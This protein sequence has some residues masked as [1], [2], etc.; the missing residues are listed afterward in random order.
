[1]KNKKNIYKSYIFTFLIV[2]CLGLLC[3]NYVFARA[4]VDGK[5]M[6]NTLHNKDILFVEKISL[7]TN[8]ISKGNIII[9]DSHNKRKEIF[10][11]RVIATSGDT[12]K[13]SN[14]KVYLNDT[15]LYEPY[16]KP[17]TFT[18][19]GDFLKENESYKVPKGYVFVM[20]DNRGDSLDSRII[21][22]VKISS[23]IGHVFIRT[24]PFKEFRAF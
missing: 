20:G 1:M 8:S 9:F 17:K 16:L 13:I 7:Y 2:L 24:F 18:S 19:P 11:K 6:E 10:V 23:I 4:D 12:I 21:G 14:G 3:K 5:S 15:K 22:P